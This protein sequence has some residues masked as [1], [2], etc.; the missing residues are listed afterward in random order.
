MDQKSVKGG[1]AKVR[2]AS[3]NQENRITG[4]ARGQ[5]L[6]LGYLNSKGLIIRGTV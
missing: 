3:D 2:V 6:K 4:A 5:Y 1:F